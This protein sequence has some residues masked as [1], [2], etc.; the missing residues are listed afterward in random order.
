FYCWIPLNCKVQVYVPPQVARKNYHAWSLPVENSY[1]LDNL[2][3]KPVK[4]REEFFDFKEVSKENFHQ[5]ESKNIDWKRYAHK[6]ILLE[7]TFSEN[8][9]DSIKEINFFKI[10][11]A[12]EERLEIMM[13]L[14]IDSFHNKSSYY[15]SLPKQEKRFGN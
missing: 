12:K 10:K 5:I 4:G 7:K 1:V 13:K 2:D 8:S 6:G 3:S 9:N 15:F 14:M 11:G